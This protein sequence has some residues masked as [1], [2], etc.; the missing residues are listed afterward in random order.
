MRGLP[1]PQ[2]D[3]A[4]AGDVYRMAYGRMK[5]LWPSTIRNGIPNHLTRGLPNDYQA[6]N[7]Y[8]T[9]AVYRDGCREVDQDTYQ[10]VDQ[11]VYHEVDQQSL[12]SRPKFTETLGLLQSASAR[13][14]SSGEKDQGIRSQE[15]ITGKYHRKRS[16]EKQEVNQDIHQDAHSVAHREAVYRDVYQDVNWKVTNTLFRTTSLGTIYTLP[17]L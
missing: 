8:S 16:W 6:T 7:G 9:A 2:L 5:E 12:P 10:E 14:L 1:G 13:R 15:K 11:E 3:R 17:I 4:T